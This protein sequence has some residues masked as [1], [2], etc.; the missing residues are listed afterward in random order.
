MPPDA[1][2]LLLLFVPLD[3]LYNATTSTLLDMTVRRGMD[4]VLYFNS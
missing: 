4:L 1:G 3:L 2:P